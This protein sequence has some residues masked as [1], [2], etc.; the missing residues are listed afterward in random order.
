MASAN[1]H[2]LA[3]FAVRYA[4]THGG[5]LIDIGSTTTDIISIERGQVIAAGLTD[6]DRLATAFHALFSPDDRPSDR[7]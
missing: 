5:L 6:P 7:I 3:T 1:W 4:L 2:A